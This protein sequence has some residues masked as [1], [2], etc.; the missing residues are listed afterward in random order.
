MFLCKEFSSH[1]NT[2]NEKGWYKYTG[3]ILKAKRYL[4]KL[5]LVLAA[6]FQTSVKASA[7]PMEGD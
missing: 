2:S 1:E 6:S 7:S 5:A 4:K 3:G